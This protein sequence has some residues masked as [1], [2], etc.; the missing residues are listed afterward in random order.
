MIPRAPHVPVAT[1]WVGKDERVRA[2]SGAMFY[3]TAKRGSRVKKGD[4]VGWMTDYVGLPLG[5]VRAPQD[6][7]VTFIRPVPSLSKGATIVTV[8]Q[9]YGRTPPVYVK[10]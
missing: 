3:A 7:A 4:K 2:D 1:T 10:P 8:A 9:I 6:G 5:D